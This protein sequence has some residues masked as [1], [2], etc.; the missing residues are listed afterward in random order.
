VT[1]VKNVVTIR[2]DFRPRKA[3]ICVCG[4]GFWP[5]GVTLYSA[6]QRPRPIGSFGWINGQP[7]SGPIKEL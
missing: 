1:I 5:R 4:R 2:R 6:S 3:H 7:E